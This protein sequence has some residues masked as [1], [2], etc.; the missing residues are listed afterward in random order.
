MSDRKIICVGHVCI[1][2]TPS[3]PELGGGRI[4]DKLS[5]GK[6]I[7]VGRA[8]TSVGGC[9]SNTGLGLKVLGADVSLMGKIGNDAFG[10]LILKEFRK[11]GADEGLIVQDEDASSYTVV[12]AIPG[13]DRIFLHHP[14]ANDTFCVSDI[15][16]E[17][18]SGAA[19]FHF[20]YPPIMRTFY[21]RDGEETVQLL[22]RA[23]ESGAATSLDMAMVDPDSDAGRQDWKK[24]LVRCLPLVD[25]FCPSIE[26]LCWMLDKERFDS[27]KE[28][29]GGRDVTTVLDVDAD[30]R[31]LAR[32]CMELGCKVL[33]I[34]CGAPGMYLKTAGRD[35][36]DEISPAAGLDSALWAD[37]DF[38]EKSYRPE[39]VLS[40]TGAGDTSIAGFLKAVLDGYDPVMTMHLAAGCGASC[41]EAYDTLSGLRSFDELKEKIASGWEKV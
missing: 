18:V 40:G 3:I 15:P 30:I 11:Y 38:F 32:E 7:Q 36:L 6:L 39:R 16:W 14:G 2:I 22:T 24:I 20:G 25:F 23:R 17:K 19:L 26:E 29:S 8:S 5:P 33:L 4:E 9:V 41:V 10:E 37:Q 13:I 12:I 1:D 28:R 21:E 31:P 27:W 35:V 34:K